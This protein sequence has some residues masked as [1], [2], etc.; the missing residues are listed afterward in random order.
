[1]RNV[2]A[3]LRRYKN[4]SELSRAS[5]ATVF[6]SARAERQHGNGNGQTEEYDLWQLI[7]N[8]HIN[9]VIVNMNKYRV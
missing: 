8:L 6:H 3:S 7:N 9:T 5:S 2:A 4:G 1:M